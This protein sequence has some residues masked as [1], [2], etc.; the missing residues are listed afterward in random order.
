M[1]EKKVLKMR[2]RAEKPTSRASLA[3]PGPRPS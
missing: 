1:K 3:R 2:K